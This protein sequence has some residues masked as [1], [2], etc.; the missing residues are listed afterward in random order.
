MHKPPLESDWKVY[1]KRIAAWRDRYLARRNA[2]I[3]A[4]LTDEARTPTAQFWDTY[5]KM[6]KEAR[7]LD[8]SL[9]RFARSQMR[10]NILVMYR[11]GMVDDADLAEFSEELRNWVMAVTKGL[12]E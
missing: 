2:E 8:D 9:G 1:S 4:I 11:R 6:E 10:T 12:G 3:L 7:I 5:E